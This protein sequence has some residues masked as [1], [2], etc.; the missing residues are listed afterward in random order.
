MR[1]S[2]GNAKD[3][4]FARDVVA[5]AEVV[6]CALPGIS[7]DGGVAAGVAALIPELALRNARFGVVGGCAVLPM[8]AGEPRLADTG[9]FPAA[10]RPLVDAHQRTLDAL[11]AAPAELDWFIL[12]PAAEFGP[13]APGTRHG[14]YRTSRTS[15]VTDL[16]DRSSIGIE[17][18]AIAFADEIEQPTTHRAWL[19]AGY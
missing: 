3:S 4:T 6:I 15:L 9:R 16:S 10:L 8:H 5:D 14:A 13:H 19:T 1:T 18:Y 12:I 2:L 7:E 11:A 17:D